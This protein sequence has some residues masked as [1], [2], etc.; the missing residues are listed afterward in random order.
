MSLFVCNACSEEIPS[1]KVRL[2]CQICPNY[3]QCTNCYVLSQVSGSHT[4]QHQITLH[5]LSGSNSTEVPPPLLQSHGS[6]SSP[7]L[8]Q[9]LNLVDKP[10]PSPNYHSGSADGKVLVKPEVDQVTTSSEYGQS[11][12]AP[13][14][15]R[16]PSVSNTSASNVTGSM[17]N[18]HALENQAGINSSHQSFPDNPSS[19]ISQPV[20]GVQRISSTQSSFGNQAVFTSPKQWQSLFNGTNPNAIFSALCTAFFW[21]VDVQHREYL[22][23][24]TLSNFMDILGIEPHRNICKLISFTVHY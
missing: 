19:S 23:P 1:R 2:Q 22:T 17:S 3:Q 14:P 16:I 21:H 12:Y 24:E 8:Q 7:L 13:P 4:S 6:I 9:G 15:Y 20:P 10:L 18:H 5:K 11:I